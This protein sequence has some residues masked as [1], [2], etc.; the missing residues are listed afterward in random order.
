M[1]VPRQ[2]TLREGLPQE[3]MGGVVGPTRLSMSQS[4]HAT[5]ID[6]KG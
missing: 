3:E 1:K 5:G 2:E 4:L 6:R